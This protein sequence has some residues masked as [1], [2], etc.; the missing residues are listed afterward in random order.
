[1]ED[2]DRSGAPRKFDDELEL[3][4]LLNENPTQTQ[5]ELAERLGVARQTVSVRLKQLG[6]IQKLGQWVPH[7]LIEMIRKIDSRVGSVESRY[8]VAE[9]LPCFHG[10]KGKVFCTKLLLAMKDGSYMTILN[11]RNHGLISGNRRL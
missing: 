9:V 4:E 3:E 5:E 6:K 2:Y 1:M 7:G 8:S 11:D 10:I